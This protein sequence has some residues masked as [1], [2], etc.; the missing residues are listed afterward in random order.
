VP[1]ELGSTRRR[2][3][4]ERRVPAWSENPERPFVALKLATSLDGRIADLEGARAGSPVGRRAA[5][6]TGS[7][8]GSTRSPWWRTHRAADDP[9]LT[10]RGAVTAA[11]HPGRVIFDAAPTCPARSARPQCVRGAHLRRRLS[12]GAADPAHRAGR[13]RRAGRGRAHLSEGSGTRSARRHP[14]ACWSK[15]AGGSP[16]RSSAT[17]CATGSTGSRAR[18]ARGSRSARDRGTPQRAD[19]PGRAVAHGRAPR[20]GDDTLLVLD[21]ALD[22][23]RHRHRGG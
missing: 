4:T 22:V 12:A 17:G 14:A 13:A 19:R 20:A 1:V 5:T 7:A 18:L 16:A 15:E 10:V 8:P 2:G 3:G 23:H 21:R 9:S 11:D 6:C